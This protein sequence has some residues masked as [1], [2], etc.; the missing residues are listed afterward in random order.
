VMEPNSRRGLL[1]KEFPWLAV[2][3]C[4][5]HRLAIKDA[6]NFTSMT[7]AVLPIQNL[8]KKASPIGK[9]VC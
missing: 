9:G 1:N 4:L 7:E 6:L 5:S 3:W 2:N 8:F